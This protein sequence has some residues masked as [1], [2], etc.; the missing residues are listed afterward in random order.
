LG[1]GGYFRVGKLA[2]DPFR[3]SVV[4]DY[5]SPKLDL[6]HVGFLQLQNSQR[7]SL[8]L[9]YGTPWGPLRDFRMVLTAQGGWSTD[10]RLI[11]L[12]H[13]VNLEV[14]AVTSGQHT[15]VCGAT[16]VFQFFDLRELDGTGIPLQFQD[17]NDAYCE[18]ETDPA[19]AL[20]FSGSAYF[21]RQS[22][23]TPRIRFGGGLGAKLRPHARYELSLR[24]TLDPHIF[25]PYYLATLSPGE[26]LLGDLY[27]RRLSV[28]L[29]QLFVLT[30]RL[31]LEAYAQVFSTYGVYG[32]L[33]RAS[34][35]GASVRTGDL[36]PYEG[37]LP[38]N[39]NF[40]SAALRAHVGLRWDYHVGSRFMLVYTRT[41][42]T[43]PATPLRDD[44]LPRG[45]L[46]G[47]T[48][49]L[50]LLKWSYAFGT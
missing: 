17:G 46:E 40:F 9:E 19:R 36:Q 41:Q 16:Y 32:Q 10:G 47:R 33:F 22:T 30:P 8:H 35:Q 24:S 49:D 15:F 44:L 12:G 6:N 43:T 21:V 14:T 42:D 45:L 34:S 11:P 50:F 28:I 48:E 2:G 13:E 31:T 37:P 25:S 1:F 18:V 29:E 3:A 20:S 38:P 39:P 7:A 4:Y 23:P 26:F 27:G 5:A